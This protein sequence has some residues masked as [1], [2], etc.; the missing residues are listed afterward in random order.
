MGGLT[1]CSVCCSELGI[2]HAIIVTDKGIAALGIIDELTQHLGQNG[3]ACTVFDDTTPDPATSVIETAAKLAI[4]AGAN[5]VIGIGGG[6]SMDCAKLVAALLPQQQALHDMFGVNQVTVSRAPLVLIPTTA[7]TG[8]EVTPIS[9]VTTG[10]TTKSGIVSRALLPDV[11]ILDASLT[12]DLPAHITAATGIDAMVHAMEAYTSKIKKNV[13]SD[14]LAREALSLL[15]KNIEKAVAN[16]KDL[17]ARQNMML[18]ACM[19]GQAF[20][21]APVGAVHALAYPLGG[22]FH[23]PH[24]LS[25]SLVLPHVIRFNATH[26]ADLYSELSEIVIPWQ[27]PYSHNPAQRAHHLADYFASLAKQFDLPTRL[28]KVGVTEDDIAILAADAIKQER[29][30]VNNPKDVLFE[31]ALRIY[32]IAL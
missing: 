18:G 7:G 32:Q 25:N 17:T 3:I 13:Y 21:N 31:D 27:F 28:N 15:S 22:H 23:V 14:M 16:G 8:S 9:I 11:A 2:E 12:L 29:L 26:A 19:A 10:D 20:A 5:G 4:D 30:L 1:N 6:S 24:G